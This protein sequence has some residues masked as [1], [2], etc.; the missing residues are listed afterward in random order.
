MAGFHEQALSREVFGPHFLTIGFALTGGASERWLAV[1]STLALLAH[2]DLDLRTLC[3]LIQPVL[4]VSLCG[5]G[6]RR[7]A[8]VQNQQHCLRP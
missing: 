3:G 7:K 2:N 8:L 5:R 4:F 1:R 6:K